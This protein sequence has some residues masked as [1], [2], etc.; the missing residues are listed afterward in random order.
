[1]N[2]PW[3]NK[4]SLIRRYMPGEEGCTLAHIRT[5][6]PGLKA[7]GFGAIQITAPYASAGFWPWWG[8]RPMD[9]FAVNSALG[10][11]YDDFRTLVSDAHAAG[12]RV[13]IFLNLG[14]ADTSSALWHAACTPGSR[15]STFFHWSD[16]NPNAP[17]DPFFK[18]GGDWH[19]SEEAGKHYW[20]KWALGGIFAPQF[21]W[22]SPEF[23]NYAESVLVH[24]LETGID[25]VIVDAVNWY[26]NCS[27]SR[28]RKYVTDVVHRYPGVLCIPEGAGGFGEDPAAWISEG[29]F[30]VSEDQ[31][32][33][34]DLHWNG[35]AILHAVSAAD[36][37]ILTQG[38]H[39]CEQ[40]R[41]MGIPCW[42]YPSWGPDW[43]PPLRLLELA[44]LI[45]TGHM[46]EF[47]PS[48]YVDLNEQ[49]HA[50]L[51]S[52]F[53]LGHQPE[54]SPG[55][56]R[57]EIPVRG[58]GGWYACRSGAIVCLFRLSDAPGIAS[59]NLPGRWHS[60]ADNSDVT[61]SALYLPPFGY[62][63]YTE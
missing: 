5:E 38:L 45:G 6:L 14:Y 29:R 47:L 39:W 10:G 27:W 61:M 37:S 32:F 56:L 59:I 35:S 48:Y 33:H 22:S 49:E 16:S 34:S 46:T 24:W 41:R 15:E 12:L 50:S 63:F 58:D 3:W 36:G 54:L 17:A 26:L 25:G 30:D 2:R 28:I 60:L 13:L 11:G 43:A 44:V 20:C 51:R 62:G 8:L 40:A 53:R 31:P 18:Q 1:M 19:W 42:S 55:V 21:D 7:Q 57:E 23:C 9:H 4:C 52:L